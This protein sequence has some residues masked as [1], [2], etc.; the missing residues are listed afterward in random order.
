MAKTLDSVG[1]FL[2]FLAL[3]MFI[4]RLVDRQLELSFID[5]H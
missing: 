5:R 1:T 4:F 3:F 2:L